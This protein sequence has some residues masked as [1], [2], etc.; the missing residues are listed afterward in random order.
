MLAAV[1]VLLG[2]LGGVITL[3]ARVTVCERGCGRGRG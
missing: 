2:V 3:L 1:P